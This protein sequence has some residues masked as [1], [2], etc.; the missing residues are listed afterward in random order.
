VECGIAN[1]NISDISEYLFAGK[2]AFTMLKKLT[3]CPKCD[4]SCG[5]GQAIA[6]KNSGTGRNY[7]YQKCGRTTPSRPT[8]QKGYVAYYYTAIPII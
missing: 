7:G 2:L 3:G 6:S 8:T 5:C 1:I 4:V